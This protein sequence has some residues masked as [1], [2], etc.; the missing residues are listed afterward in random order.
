MYS[1][2][3]KIS[4]W[5]LFTIL[6]LTSCEQNE[7]IQFEPLEMFNRM[8]TVVVEGEVKYEKSDFYIVK[9]YI[10]KKGVDLKIDSIVCLVKD[11]SYREYKEY[12]ILLYKES[13]MT[14]KEKLLENDR[15]LVRYSQNHDWIYIYAWHGGI[16]KKIS[17]IKVE[18]GYYLDSGGT[19]LECD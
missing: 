18:N 17:R 4:C 13:M 15:I 3:K 16:S 8:D 5:I 9:N 12:A 10:D 11:P 7:P 14:N 6:I 2:L 19:Y 1:I